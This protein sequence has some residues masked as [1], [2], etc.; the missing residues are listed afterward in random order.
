[1]GL[2]GNWIYAQHTKGN[3]TGP[4]LLGDFGSMSVSAANGIRVWECSVTEFLY[5]SSEM[6]EWK[7]RCL[8]IISCYH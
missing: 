3:N 4:C 8:T 2:S 5:I 6:C 7:Y 1:M